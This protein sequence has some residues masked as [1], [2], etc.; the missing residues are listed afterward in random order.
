[1]LAR[2]ARVE[3]KG[4]VVRWRHFW[5]DLH[6]Q[7]AL[8]SH[9]SGR[10]RDCFYFEYFECQR[11]SDERRGLKRGGDLLIVPRTGEMEEMAAWAHKMLPGIRHRSLQLSLVSTVTN[12]RLGVSGSN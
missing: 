7:H 10:A 9:H 1:M 6:A 5:G 2:T 4:G 12:Y 11:R 8:L 3:L